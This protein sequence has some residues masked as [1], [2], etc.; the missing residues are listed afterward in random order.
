MA[1]LPWVED[2]PVTEAKLDSDES[3]RC[4]TTSEL[5][6]W[7]WIMMAAEWGGGRETA[8]LA[9][10]SAGVPPWWMAFVS[11]SMS[12]FFLF[13]QYPLMYRFYHTEEDDALSEKQ[14]RRLIQQAI[15]KTE[16]KMR[17]VVDWDVWKMQEREISIDV[18]IPYKSTMETH[19]S[20]IHI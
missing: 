16:K 10:G 4:W 19:L 3:R 6:N 7:G 13:V 14:L 5:G 20:L 2:D 17:V 8:M 9:G 1:W 11:M 12:V 15:Q 18:L